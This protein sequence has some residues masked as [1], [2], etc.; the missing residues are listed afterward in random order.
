[1]IKKLA[2]ISILIP[3]LFSL[4][5]S[6]TITTKSKEALELF[7]QAQDKI[8]NYLTTEVLPDLEQAVKLDKNFALAWSVL[9]A[10]YSTMGDS[11]KAKEA[12]EKAKKLAPK[13]TEYEKMRISIREASL[14]NNNERV[15]EIIKQMA[16]KFPEDKRALYIYGN[17]LFNLKRKPEQAIELYNK[18]VA[19][20]P[21]YSPVYNML[22]YAYASMGKF[23]KSL[24][25]L[26]KY[27]ELLPDHFNP[28]DSYGEILLTVGRYDEALKH[29]KKA[30]ELKPNVYFVHK[31]IANTSSAQGSYKEAKEHFQKALAVAQNDGEK[32]DAHYELALIAKA[33]GNWEETKK[34]AE[35][36]SSL[37]PERPC[38]HEIL[39]DFYLDQN[40][41]EEAKIEANKVREKIAKWTKE[42]DEDI[43]VLS[44]KAKLLAAE[45]NYDGAIPLL[46]KG[47]EKAGSFEELYYRL[48]LA[49]V[50]F[51]KKDY[52]NAIAE[53]NK[54]L[55][56]NPNNFEIRLLL[57]KSYG[58]KKGEKEKA[59]AEFNKVLEILA[60]ADEG[61]KPVAE[62]KENLKKLGVK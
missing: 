20:D 48:E 38:P 10:V 14:A 33:L 59:K 35:L 1:M 4:A 12:F 39:M 8:D 9:S 50:Y 36:C 16:E 27:V 19:I 56:I 3:L 15:F 43:F 2:F 46:L 62:A 42:P 55:L 32:G 11:I 52:D 13:V 28:H 5:Q 58:K 31:H 24:E 51:D 6:Q 44:V 61:V 22:G 57:A 23:D 21:N 30:Y 60:N 54:A 40:K 26:G 53:L 41:L 17:Q 45:K 47:M 7:K 18:V 29:F 25:A 34:E 49:K 37:D